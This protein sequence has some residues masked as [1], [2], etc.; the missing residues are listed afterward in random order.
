M[1]NSGFRFWGAFFYTS[2]WWAVIEGCAALKGGDLAWL[3]I[4]G[5]IYAALLSFVFFEMGDAD[6]GDAMG[7]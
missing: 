2:A 3:W 4:C 7:G 6:D 5:A 1:K